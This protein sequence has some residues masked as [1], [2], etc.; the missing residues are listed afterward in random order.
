MGAYK[1]LNKQDAYITSRTAHKTYVLENT[2]Y[3]DAGIVIKAA[4][5]SLYN[6]VKQLYYPP[7]SEGNVV[8]HSY[9]HYN[10][11]TLHNPDTRQNFNQ[12]SFGTS[13]SLVMS[14]PRSLYGTY[15]KPGPPFKLRLFDM[16][17][18][19]Y[20]LR[21]YN[22]WPD[23]SPY[24]PEVL[25]EDDEVIEQEN[26]TVIILDDEEGG[27]YVYGTDPRRY[28]GDIIYSHGILVFTD[29]AAV[30]GITTTEVLKSELTWQTSHP[31]FTHTYHCRVKESEFNYTYN[32][33]T[34][35]PSTK[36]DI[37]I[38]PVYLQSQVTIGTQTWTDK[39]LNVATYSDGTPIPQVTDS[40]QWYSLTTG[41]WCY[42]NN[43]P[44]S[45]A[46]YGKLYNWYAVAGIYDAESLAYPD[47]RKKLAPSGYH[48]PFNE[49][50]TTLTDYLG[51]LEVA[52]SKMKST[53]NLYDGTGLW[54]TSAI[55][56][57]NNSSGFTALPGGARVYSGEFV[58]ARGAGS[59]WSSSEIDNINAWSRA[60]DADVDEVFIENNSKKMGFSVRCVYDGLVHLTTTTTTTQT[61]ILKGNVTGSAF[62]PYITT[63]GLY[64][65]ANEL[66]AVGKMGQPIPKSANTE[67]TIVVKIDI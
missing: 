14:I 31:I 64:N 22:Y 21:E 2:Q 41:A 57:G 43:D 48:V 3:L 45:E 25:P 11:T 37:T 51:G 16:L 26:E 29:P 52:A 15:I 30:A 17:E 59:W 5:G 55:E 44:S 1:K 27:L 33:T 13:G 56:D 19:P 53:G 54:N 39:N 47:L 6:S 49:D 67:M 9:D 12:T 34:T 7:T 63:V 58:S 42:Y 46:V 40:Q 35:T 20:I 38:L 60:L 65:D 28:V 8:S 24:T 10:Q 4:S 66:I 50:W 23:V 32:P 61:G 62:Q 36:T 18:T